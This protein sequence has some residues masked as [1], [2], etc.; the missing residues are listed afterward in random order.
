MNVKVRTIE[1]DAN[2]ADL[3]EARAAARGLSVSDLIADLA[4]NEQALPADMAG[5]RANGE[6]PW[7]AEM[8]TE[9]A[10]RLAEF[11]R[12]REGIPWDEVKVWMQSW[13]SAHELP[14]P[15]PRKL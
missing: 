12:T 4:Y 9:D 1:V 5:M 8:L 13:G 15:K 14:P 3:L 6:G 2:T 7:S 11:T 10:E